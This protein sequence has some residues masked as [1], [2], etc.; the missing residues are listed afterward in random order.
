MSDTTTADLIAAVQAAINADPTLSQASVAAA[1]D[2]SP[3]VLGQ[4]ISFMPIKPQ[5]EHTAEELA[6]AVRYPDG[7]ASWD[8]IK[9]VPYRC[10]PVKSYPV[11]TVREPIT[12]DPPGAQRRGSAPAGTVRSG[13]LLALRAW[14]LRQPAPFFHADARAAIPDLHGNYL[15]R[16][17]RLGLLK[18]RVIKAPGRRQEFQWLLAVLAWPP[19]PAGWRAVASPYP[20]H[21]L[22]VL[23][24]E[25]GDE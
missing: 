3:A 1:L 20:C 7:A 25:V 13:Q 8:P 22:A 4:M 14:C 10:Y 18:V 9:A 6:K 5:P 21:R 11:K 12:P 23:V 2:Y 17:G 19:V 15:G 16:L 24:V